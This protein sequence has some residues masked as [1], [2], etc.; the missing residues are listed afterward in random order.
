MRSSAQRLESSPPLSAAQWAERGEDEPGELVDGQIVAEEEVTWMH[1]ETAAWLIGVLWPWLRERGGR[2]ATS[3][4]RY[5]IRLDRGRKPDLSI[6]LPGTPMPAPRSALLTTPPTIAVEILSPR[7]SDIRR[8]RVE[9]LVDYAGFGVQ[10]YWLVDPNVRLLEVFR[11]R[12]EGPSERVLGATE[13]EV[14]V[15][16]CPGLTLDLDDLWR[17]VDGG[18]EE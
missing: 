8:D 16:G 1:D 7:P 10:W 4:V 17:Q 3:D 9:K 5:Q 6:F 2:V 12:A 13:G 15:P 18:E 11:L 14:L